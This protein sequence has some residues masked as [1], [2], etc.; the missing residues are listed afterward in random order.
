MNGKAGKS[1]KGKSNNESRLR[2]GALALPPAPLSGPAT[3]VVD[4]VGASHRK[5]KSAT[6]KTGRLREEKEGKEKEKRPSTRKIISKSK[7]KRVAKTSRKEVKGEEQP[8]CDDFRSVRGGQ[9]G[10][11]FQLRSLPAG[12]NSSDHTRMS[13]PSSPRARRTRSSKA[14][15]SLLLDDTRS[16]HGS[17]ISSP[18]A[19]LSTPPSTPRGTRR[20]RSSLRRVSDSESV[21]G[22]QVIANNCPPSPVTPGGKSVEIFK[23][24]S[25][26]EGQSTPRRR[27]RKIASSEHD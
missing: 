18:A 14:S 17:T 12:S 3:N 15:K 8:V 2:K 9:D 6:S 21:T 7:S 10:D 26:G 13:A 27:R 24:N 11:E 19:S 1:K 5:N 20:V 23:W 22:M 4:D 25:R 16:D